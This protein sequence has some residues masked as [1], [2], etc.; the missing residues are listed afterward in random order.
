MLA[1]SGCPFPDG[2]WQVLQGRTSAPLPAATICGT[3]SCAAGAAAGAPPP[4]PPAAGAG[5]SGLGVMNA[6]SGP[7]ASAAKATSGNTAPTS[8]A[9]TT[10]FIRNLPENQERLG[11]PLEPQEY[12]DCPRPTRSE[13]TST[14]IDKLAF[15]AATCA[16]K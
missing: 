16:G 2:V 1:D 14:A 10:L 3:P 6:Q 4:P 13:D 15:C 12:C 5:A 11:W 7:G 8:S 9:Q